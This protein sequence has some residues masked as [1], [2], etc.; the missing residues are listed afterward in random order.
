MPAAPHL[1]PQCDIPVQ[2]E[3]RVRRRARVAERHHE[4]AFMPAGE[5]GRGWQRGGHH[6]HAAGH[7]LHHLGG[8]RV[9]EV[10]LIVQ[11]RQAGQRAVQQRHGLV[12]RH[13]AA[14]AQQARRL[15]GLDLSPG[16]RVGRSDQLHRDA[17][18]TQQPGQLDHVAGAPVRRQVA[19]VHHPPVI[20]RRG[21]G[22]RHVGGVRHHRMRPGEPGDVPLLGQDQVHVPL[23]HPF[24]GVHRHGG[25][26]PERTRQ[27]R[28]GAERGGGVLVHIPDH[29]RPP[30]PGGQ[31]QQQFGVVDEQQV[32]VGRVLGQGRTGRANRPGP[33]SSRGPRNH[34]EVEQR[35][36]PFGTKILLIHRGDVRDL[37]TGIEQ[38]AYLPVV[39]ARVGRMMNDCAHHHP[40]RGLLPG[41][42]ASTCGAAGVFWTTPRVSSSSRAVRAIWARS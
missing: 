35:P 23:G 16:A 12:V 40:H 41:Q 20:A 13:E 8:Q 7:V 42:R 26:R 11:Q 25:G 1:R 10:R 28:L 5:L 19:D 17:A 34:F 31:R 29:R 33:A 2:F 4:A 21:R 22:V 6:R 38:G 3:H 32:G 39:D 18:R 27:P 36:G 37:V 14:P 9:P 15:R 24:R 30:A